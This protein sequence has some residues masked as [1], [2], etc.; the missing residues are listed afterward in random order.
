MPMPFLIALAQIVQLGAKPNRIDLITSISG[1]EFEEA[2]N[3]N[4]S[5]R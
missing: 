4:V 1:V 2:W 5:S 3:P